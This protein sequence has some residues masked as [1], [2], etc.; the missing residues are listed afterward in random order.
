MGKSKK[1]PPQQQTK[2]RF[3]L[4]GE[5]ISGDG[6]TVKCFPIFSLSKIQKSHCLTKCTQE[7]KAAFA[8]TLHKLSQRQW[9]NILS[10]DRH[11]GGQEKIARNAIQETIPDFVTEDTNLIA[12]RFCGKAPM[13]GFKKD[14]VFYVLW[15]DRDFTL[16]KH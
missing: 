10:S 1:L 16:Y 11:K 5:S 6:S 3:R 7:E 12:L 15:L 14:E 13:V 4:P 9:V 8:D 2:S